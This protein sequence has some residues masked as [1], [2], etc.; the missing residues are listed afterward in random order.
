MYHWG[1]MLLFPSVCRSVFLSVPL[2]FYLSSILLSSFSFLSLFLFSLSLLLWYQL[3]NNFLLLRLFQ[4]HLLIALLTYFIPTKYYSAQPSRPHELPIQPYQLLSL[5][6]NK[7]FDRFSSNFENLKIF[8]PSKSH[9]HC[10]HWS[11]MP[12]VTDSGQCFLRGPSLSI[13][14]TKEIR[15]LI[16]TG[17]SFLFSSGSHA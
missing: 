14:I 16:L 13:R 17:L 7:C 4:L 5:S 12:C 2:S 3:V 1:K 10:G 6:L 8:E 9:P 11:Q 15:W